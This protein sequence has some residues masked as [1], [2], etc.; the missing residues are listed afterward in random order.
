MKRLLP[1]L[2]SL[3]ML[4]AGAPAFA[5]TVV[6]LELEELVKLSDVIVVADVRSVESFVDEGRVH[7]RIRLEVAERWKGSPGE[8]V[9]IVHLGGRT[10]KLATV[11]HG[12]PAFRQGERVLVFLEK[13]KGHPHY[14]VTGLSQGKFSLQMLPDGSTLVVP[15]IDYGSLAK[16]VKMPDNSVQLKRVEPVSIPRERLEA[17]RSRIESMVKA[18]STE[19]ETE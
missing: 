5:T 17:F 4:L 18:Q 14:V 6:K 13:P 12:M 19:L 3:S 9:E 2:L 10:E 7:T 16:P 11:V 8:T 15:E 1:F